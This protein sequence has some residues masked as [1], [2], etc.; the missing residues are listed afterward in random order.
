MANEYPNVFYSEK[1]EPYENIEP[2]QIPLVEN[3]RD[4]LNVAQNFNRKLSKQQ[5]ADMLRA[6]KQLEDSGQI[7]EV[8][9]RV[10]HQHG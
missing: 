7:E 8:Y 4:H 1:I 5:Q 6:V 10:E 9:E 3:Y 2:V